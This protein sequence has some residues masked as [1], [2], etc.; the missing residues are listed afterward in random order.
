MKNIYILR[1]QILF[2]DPILF[3]T[4]DEDIECIVYVDYYYWL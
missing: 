3:V 1:F 2:S 4:V